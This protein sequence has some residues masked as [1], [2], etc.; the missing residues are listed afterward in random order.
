[1]RNSFLPFQ[2]ERANRARVGI[3]VMRKGSK[4]RVRK[5]QC[6]SFIRGIMSAIVCSV[7]KPM[8][9]DIEICPND[10]LTGLY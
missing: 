6:E 5:F 9:Y 7:L 2:T 3:M 4:L 1:M 8:D 10:I